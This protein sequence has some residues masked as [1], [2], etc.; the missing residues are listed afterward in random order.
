MP[1][2]AFI[3]LETWHHVAGVYS[4]DAVTLYIDGE[5]VARE[6]ANGA[7]LTA[8][9]ES[10]LFI[11]TKSD[12]APEGDWWDGRIDEVA[13]FDRALSPEEVRGVM[14]GLVQGLMGA[15][16]PAEQ[17]A[18]ATAPAIIRTDAPITVDGDLSEWAGLGGQL[19][20]DS[21]MVADATDVTDDSDLSL[22][23][24]LTYDDGWVYLGARVSDDVLVFER[25][26]DAIWQND[27]LEVWL[28][29]Q[30][31]AAALVDE[32]PYLHA[33]GGADTADAE[34]AVVPGGASEGGG[35]T[36]ELAIPRAALEEALET[37]L[38]AGVSLP[39]AVG[40]NDADEAGGERLGQIYFPEGW[41]WGEPDS[42]EV[43][44]FTP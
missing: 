29:G 3:T 42:F 2:D 43:L 16:P 39:V 21:S 4:G 17:P 19:E 9:A 31:F 6:E 8:P 34:V 15:A 27:S 38:G 26:G 5:E 37:S 10:R 28:G 44:E 13:I 32:A 40:A 24:H 14:Q 12:L 41:T 23:A 30:Q 7:V 18:A 36:V 11:G 25:T 22:T 20:V 1:Q 35:Y 33:F